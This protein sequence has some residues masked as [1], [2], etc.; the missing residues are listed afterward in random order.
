LIIGLGGTGVKVLTLVKRDLMATHQGEVPKEVQLLAFDTEIES[1]VQAGVATAAT[2]FGA[3]GAVKLEKE[4][5][6]YV[7]IGGNVRDYVRDVARGKFPH[8]SSWLQAA[9]YLDRLPD[10]LFFLEAGAGM[11]RQFGR[12]AIFYDVLKGAGLS[13]I[14]RMTKQAIERVQKARRAETIH[15]MLVSSVAGGTGAG[16]FVDMAYLVRQIARQE[17]RVPVALRGFLVMPEAFGTIPSGVTPEMRARAYAAMRE[18]KRFMVAPDWEDGYPMYYHG[19]E[20]RGDGDDIWQGAAKSKLFDFL[21]HIDGRRPKNRLDT[22]PLEYGI[23]PTVADVIAAFLDEEGGRVFEQ[24]K[25]NLNKAVEQAALNV[26]STPFYGT[27]G[28]Y[29]YVLP[30]YHIVEDFAHRLALEVLEELMG[31]RDGRED[32][33]RDG[34]PIRL[35]PDRNAEAGEGRPGRDDALAF[36]DRDVFRSMQDSDVEVQP[37]PLIRE[38]GRVAGQAVPETVE[39]VRGELT[40]RDLDTWMHFFEPLYAEVEATRREVQAVLQRR[41]EDVVLTS[42]KLREKP[43][44]GLRRI[45]ENVKSYKAQ[46]LGAEREGGRREGGDFRRALDK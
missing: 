20:R 14:Y 8:V 13:R 27:V 26:N 37:T 24:H 46:H 18:N 3:A 34:V 28:T 45:E 2:A 7:W 31:L 44:D 32:R 23:A 35:P 30:M 39:Q 4:R 22:A 9:W 5:G 43:V 21:Y 25:I 16:M 36:L 33:D 41:V 38:V 10:A 12:L 11:L 15:V 29:A 6:E 40:G 1:N 19:T 42:D 17:L